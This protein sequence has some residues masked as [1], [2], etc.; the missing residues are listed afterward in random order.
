MRHLTTRLAPLSRDATALLVGLHASSNSKEDAALRVVV[1]TRPNVLQFVENGQIMCVVRARVAIADVVDVG[2]DA[3]IFVSTMDG[4]MWLVQLPSTRQSPHKP[5]VLEAN[6]S[7]RRLSA[8]VP[9]IQRMQYLA[10]MDTLVC[11]SLL[12]P[13]TVLCSVTTQPQVVEVDALEADQSTA[14][15]IVDVQDQQYHPLV[16]SVLAP[17]AEWQSSSS[18]VLVLQGD[19]DG[20]V[21]FALV[22]S[23]PRQCVHS[24]ELIRL[25]E[26]VAALVPF[27]STTG[28]VDALLVVGTRGAAAVWRAHGSQPRVFYP[29]KHPVSSI[30]VMDG[31]LAA[32]TFV[33]STST[34]ETLAVSVEQFLQQAFAIDSTPSIQA[35]SLPSDVTCLACSPHVS[36]LCQSGRLLAFSHTHFQSLLH[37]TKRED[38]GHIDESRIKTLLHDITRVSAQSTTLQAASS[39]IDTLLRELDAGLRLLRRFQHR[40][41]ESVM[42]CAMSLRLVDGGWN[43]QTKRIQLRVHLQP[44][45]E[46]LPTPLTFWQLQ[47]IVSDAEAHSTS[48]RLT[49]YAFPLSDS[50]SAGQVMVLDDEVLREQT[51]GRLR[52]TCRLLFRPSDE[53][54]SSVDNPDGLAV[55]VSTQD[56]HLIQLSEPETTTTF[57]LN[58]AKL[59]EEASGAQGTEWWP[60]VQQHASDHASGVLGPPLSSAEAHTTTPVRVVL[61]IHRPAPAS[62]TS[63]LGEDEVFAIVTRLM[64]PA[65]T[66]TPESQAQWRQACRQERGKW[67]IGLYTFA[68]NLVVLR[69]SA[70]TSDSIEISIQATSVGDMAAMRAL[71]IERL[72]TSDPSQDTESDSVARVS[73]AVADHRH[74]L[75]ALCATLEELEHVAENGVRGNGD[76]ALCDVELL[77]L[78]DRVA[79]MET[80]TLDIYWRSRDTLSAFAI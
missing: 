6:P 16:C 39:R 43:Q 8:S 67:W 3:K 74:E 68:R 23:L 58:A 46:A 34:G 41:V 80:R 37:T 57:T 10:S 27:R 19:S 60:T 77:R 2:S 30:D 78:L 7:V 22:D 29:F 79:N 53:A 28:G 9:G 45:G 38:N 61:Q 48:Q 71:V 49:S 73:M 66:E 55:T 26:P 18:G 33:F 17:S 11:T 15:V 65:E 51:S 64:V 40:T 56:F 69:L 1:R 54:S 63:L 44:Q 24:G 32:A 14:L 75:S 52:V 50:L 13:T 12:M 35:L 47:L 21:R 42:T 72:S 31:G 4:A 70:T 76:P 62:E 5:I 36:V 20:G 25:P 59:R